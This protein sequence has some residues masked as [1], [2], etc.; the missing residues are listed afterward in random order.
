MVLKD[1]STA[2]WPFKGGLGKKQR[3][4]FAGPD[5]SHTGETLSKEITNCNSNVA[6]FSA[7]DSVLWEHTFNLAG[8]VLQSDEKK[9]LDTLVL[10][11]EAPVAGRA[12]TLG[13]H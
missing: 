9:K 4:G 10:P 7:D 2:V 12:V 5:L 13:K 6:V 11:R 3:K 1:L 8:T